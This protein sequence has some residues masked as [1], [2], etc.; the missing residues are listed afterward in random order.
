MVASY[1]GS[2]LD[3]ENSLVHL[4]EIVEQAGSLVGSDFRR[5]GVPKDQVRKKLKELSNAPV[6]QGRHRGQHHG[7]LRGVT[8]EELQDARDTALRLAAI[9]GSN[10]RLALLAARD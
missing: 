6:R 2:L 5:L 9:C 10:G 3:S 1:R 7:K 8:S 4:Y